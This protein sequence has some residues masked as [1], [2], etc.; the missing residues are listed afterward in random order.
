K[1]HRLSNRLPLDHALPP[2][3]PE[4]TLTHLPASDG[5]VAIGRNGDPAVGVVDAEH[6]AVAR[7]E[8]DPF[9]HRIGDEHPR[10]GE[11]SGLL[12]RAGCGWSVLKCCAN[13]R[14]RFGATLSVA[15]RA[16]RLL[17]I[18]DVWLRAFL[19]LKWEAL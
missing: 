4:L 14:R 16:L 2:H 19:L 11:T 1:A 10:K 12:L 9:E 18:T 13:E 15:L 7:Q 3:T 8:A 17:M 6:D 5:V